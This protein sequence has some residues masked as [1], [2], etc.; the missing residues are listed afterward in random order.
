M[1]A[2]NF[3]SSGSRDATCRVPAL[4]RHLPARNEA[5]RRKTFFLAKH[6]LC[7]LAGWGLFSGRDDLARGQAPAFE[8]VSQASRPLCCGVGDVSYPERLAIDLQTNL[9]VCGSF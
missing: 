5:I 8:W 2:G 4:F 1:S 7:L 3:H 6:V 9:Y